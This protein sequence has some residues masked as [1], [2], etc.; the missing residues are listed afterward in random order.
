MVGC[1]TLVWVIETVFGFYLT[2][3]I[4][5]CQQNVYKEDGF[6]IE[7]SPLYIDVGSLKVFGI[8]LKLFGI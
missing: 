6:H 1:F 8:L 5:A 2:K 3:T 4:N 7:V